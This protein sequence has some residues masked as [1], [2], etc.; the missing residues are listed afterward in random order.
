MRHEGE[1]VPF[2]LLTVAALI[3]GGQ[4]DDWDESEEREQ[5]V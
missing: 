1:S 2:T 3:R 5:Q 4:P